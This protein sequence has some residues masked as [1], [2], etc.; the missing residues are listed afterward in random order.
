[1]AIL[2]RFDEEVGWGLDV[3]LGDVDGIV[4]DS[5]GEGVKI[6]AEEDG[7]SVMLCSRGS[8]VVRLF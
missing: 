4:W 7:G 5:V 2:E 8:V 1:M 3:I 6:G